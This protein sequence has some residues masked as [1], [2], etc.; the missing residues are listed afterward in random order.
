MMS[1]PDLNV[2]LAAERQSVLAFEV[3]GSKLPARI[4]VPRT[5]ERLRSSVL[6]RCRPA[7]RELL[8]MTELIDFTAT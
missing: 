3:A 1:C 7:A 6:T 5:Q 2:A 8:N 4:R